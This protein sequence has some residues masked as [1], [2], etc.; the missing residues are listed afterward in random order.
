MLYY[1][2]LQNK[3]AYSQNCRINVVIKCV[4]IAQGEPT[5]GITT[6]LILIFSTAIGNL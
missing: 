1:T 3:N 2:R 5:P 6:S 4:R